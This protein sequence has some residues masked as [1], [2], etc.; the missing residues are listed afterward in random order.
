MRLNYF[1]KGEAANEAE[2]QANRSGREHVVIKF[3]NQ[4][5]VKIGTDESAIYSTRKGWIPV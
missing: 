4:F 5:Q 1:T 3:N 2:K